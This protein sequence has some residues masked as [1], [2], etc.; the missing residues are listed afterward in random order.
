MTNI[1][2]DIQRVKLTDFALQELLNLPLSHAGSRAE[3]SNDSASD[4]DMTYSVS[5]FKVFNEEDIIL[6]D[7][8]INVLKMKQNHCHPG[9][10]NL[11]IIKTTPSKEWNG[12]FQSTC[13]DRRYLSTVSFLKFAQARVSAIFGMIGGSL[14]NESNIHGP[15]V[16]PTHAFGNKEKEADIDVAFII[17]CQSWPSVAQEW[18]YRERQHNWPDAP[19][20]ESIKGLTCGFVPIGYSENLIVRSIEWRI[21]FNA[22]ERQLMWSFNETQLL[23]LDFLKLLVSSHIEPHFPKLLCSYFMKTLLFWHIEETP[24]TMWRPENLVACLTECIAKLQNCLITANCPHYFIR[25]N[26]MF[27]KKD[28]KDLREASHHLNSLPI[29]QLILRFIQM[30]AN[31]FHKNV[32]FQNHIPLISLTLSRHLMH[33]LSW[34]TLRTKIDLQEPFLAAVDGIDHGIMEQL[35]HSL[36]STIG[37]VLQTTSSDDTG[38]SWKLLKQGTKSDL[39]AGPLKLATALWWNGRVLDALDIVDKMVRVDLNQ[40]IHY[41]L[42]YRSFI[43]E[44]SDVSHPIDEKMTL[45][46]IMTRFIALDVIFLPVEINIAPDFVKFQLSNG[47]P[48]FISPI[49]YTYCLEFSCHKEKSD[50]KSMADTY[51]K[52]CKARSL[53]S[54][55]G[56]PHLDTDLKGY[57]QMELGNYLKSTR[58]LVSSILARKANIPSLWLLST[59]LHK[60]FN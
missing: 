36:A 45:H 39:M 6:N 44:P 60:Y 20:I 41:S 28:K 5:N 31:F 40:V 25:N 19:M 32:I 14:K 43:K 27:D 23:C 30:K 10:C 18:L 58:F 56:L 24:S 59:L 1:A 52:F 46:D 15:C 22:A 13:L 26:N 34:E 49:V 9:Y 7:E 29:D 55:G 37:S 3:G 12:L 4:T 54:K 48:L 33:C 11:E 42:Y 2:I 8:N 57:F 53:F 50:L 16:T 35:N 21:S 38:R 51:D 47:S 17:Q